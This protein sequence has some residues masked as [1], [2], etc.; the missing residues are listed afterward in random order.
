MSTPPACSHVAGVVQFSD[1]TNNF[2]R[3]QRVAASPSIV[4]NNLAC[5]DLASCFRALAE[6]APGFA[7]MI[8]SAIAH[9][10][11]VQLFGRLPE[12]NKM[13]GRQSR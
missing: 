2:I 4:A 7:V 11:P 9:L 13:L 6:V 10:E 1:C 12:R 8:K 5:G 3:L